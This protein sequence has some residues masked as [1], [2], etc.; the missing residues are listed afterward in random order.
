MLYPFILAVLHPFCHSFIFLS[1]TKKRLQ[2][3]K[4]TLGWT[5]TEKPSDWV[6]S[7]LM[8]I[9]R[10]DS[11]TLMEHLK[12]LEDADMISDL[13]LTCA[14]ERKRQ[15]ILGLF[16]HEKCSQTAVNVCVEHTIST[17]EDSDMSIF[18]LENAPKLVAIQGPL[19]PKH[20]GNTHLNTALCSA[21]LS[22]DLELIRKLLKRGADPN[23][24][25]HFI[26]FPVLNFAV[27]SGKKLSIIEALLDAGAN[28]NLPESVIWQLF[29]LIFDT[30]QN[31]IS[32]SPGSEYIFDV[33]AQNFIP[34]T[35]GS[36]YV[37]KLA[38]LLRMFIQYDAIYDLV[39]EE[40]DRMFADYHSPL[41]IICEFVYSRFKGPG[42]L[43]IDILLVAGCDT[44]HL[45][46]QQRHKFGQD[47]EEHEKILSYVCRPLSLKCLSRKAIRSSVRGRVRQNIS[48]LPIPELLKQYLRF[49]DLDAFLIIPGEIYDAET[50]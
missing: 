23:T 47:E 31:L 44:N 4:E 18:L 28:P 8:A 16:A 46:T 9:V 11:D 40:P 38:I 7:V 42:K 10:D 49:S 39:E 43:F 21:V 5:D 2:E 3:L 36:E 6:K 33:A 48:L 14:T 22:R 30:A 20:N 27:S 25:I 50:I 12:G 29:V 41:E 37:F 19:S 45:R 26:G 32:Q 17:T 13:L 35:P 15:C 34:Q 24:F 1:L